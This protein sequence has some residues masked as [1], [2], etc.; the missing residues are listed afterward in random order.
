M[1]K[2]VSIASAVFVTRHICVN[3]RPSAVRFLCVLCVSFAAILSS[4]PL[5]IPKQMDMQP[6]AVSVTVTFAD[7]D[8]R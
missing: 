8:Q 5:G 2:L 6:V 7:I 3:L 4:R 1:D